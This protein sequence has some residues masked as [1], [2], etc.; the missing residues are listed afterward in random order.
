MAGCAG[1]LGS[2][3]GRK[4]CKSIKIHCATSLGQK[5]GF[6][7]YMLS[8]WAFACPVY[9]RGWRA[10]CSHLSPTRGLEPH[11][12]SHLAGPD[13]SYN[14]GSMSGNQRTTVEVSFL[15]PPCGSQGPIG[16]GHSAVLAEPSHQPLLVFFI[17]PPP[18]PMYLF[19]K[20]KNKGQSGSAKQ[21]ACFQDCHAFDPWCPH[22]GGEN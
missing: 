18:P 17:P 20:S 22:G 14:E 11:L 4:A 10:A 16:L 7:V 6:T 21:G 15:P 2:A 1:D 9:V 19:F 5:F 13:F 3:P 12:P 8:G